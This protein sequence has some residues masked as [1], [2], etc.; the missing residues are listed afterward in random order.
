[1]GDVLRT[2]AKL[3]RMFVAGSE[4]GG[5]AE[6][7]RPEQLLAACLVWG[8]AEIDKGYVW[9]HLKGSQNS[10]AL[11]TRFQ[12]HFGACRNHLCPLKPNLHL[13]APQHEQARVRARAG[14][15]ARAADARA[16][17]SNSHSR[18][19][20]TLIIQTRSE[21]FIGGE[22]AP[23]FI[24]GEGLNYRRCQREPPPCRYRL[25]KLWPRLL[26]VCH[27]PGME[28]L[29]AAKEDTETS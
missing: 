3:L 17:S 8:A 22:W 23:R 18:E 28:A 16:R 20:A 11:P 19:K 7:R 2:L 1:M 4:C 9:S 27:L 15:K 21:V 6:G 24:F 26:S 14:K 12:T 13:G 25:S 29:E 5:E 10:Q